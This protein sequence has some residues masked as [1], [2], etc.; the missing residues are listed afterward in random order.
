MEEEA[1]RPG[2]R[3]RRGGGGGR[4]EERTG[5]SWETHM[6]SGHPGAFQEREPRWGW[7]LTIA[8]RRDPCYPERPCR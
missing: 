8:G 7:G 3:G 5:G 4:Q 2:A 1:G 6:L